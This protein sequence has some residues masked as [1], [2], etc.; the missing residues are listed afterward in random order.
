MAKKLW[1]DEEFETLFEILKRE[2]YIDISLDE[3]ELPDEALKAIE[4]YRELILDIKAWAESARENLREIEINHIKLVNRFIVAWNEMGEAI[5][6]AFGPV[7]EVIN[8]G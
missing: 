4:E 6:E 5:S 7:W 2:K 1:T 8:W 3:D